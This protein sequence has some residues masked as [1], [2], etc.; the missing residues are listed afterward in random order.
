MML[1]RLTLIG[2]AAVS[3]AACSTVQRIPG[4]PGGDRGAESTVETVLGSR[5]IG[6]DI[7]VVRVASNGCTQKG[8]FTVEVRRRD[9]A[10]NVMLE[11]TREDY[12]RALMPNGVEIAFGFEE[13]GVPEG[14]TVRV[15]NPQQ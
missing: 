2:A 7:L 8:D 12:C 9:G 15:A 1:F 13:L 14:A 5:M 6:N 4:I 10:Y 11:R 3:L